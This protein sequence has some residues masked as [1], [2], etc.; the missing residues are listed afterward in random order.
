MPSHTER[1]RTQQA[2]PTQHNVPDT[3]NIQPRI[4]DVPKAEDSKKR[5]LSY[6]QESCSMMQHLMGPPKLGKIQQIYRYVLN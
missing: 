6:P 4:S 2:Q 3:K 1:K 5:K